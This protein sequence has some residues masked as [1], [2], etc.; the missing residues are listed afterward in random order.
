MSEIE[1]RKL[2]SNFSKRKIYIYR[3][4]NFPKTMTD[5]IKWKISHYAIVRGAVA[6]IPY[7]LQTSPR[8][9]LVRFAGIRM[10]VRL[11]GVL[12]AGIYVLQAVH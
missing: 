9:R 10:T 11:S 3:Q 4:N 6:K 12:H 2:I 7:L 8:S 1:K 5:W